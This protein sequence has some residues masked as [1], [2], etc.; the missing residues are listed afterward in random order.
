MAPKSVTICPS[1]DNCPSVYCLGYSSGHFPV[2]TTSRLPPPPSSSANCI[3][4]RSHCGCPVTLLPLVSSLARVNCSWVPY[5]RLI[6]LCC[7]VS[8]VVS[9]SAVFGRLSCCFVLSV[10]SCPVALCSSHPCFLSTH[11]ESPA[12]FFLPFLLPLHQC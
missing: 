6:C 9:C 3:P 8:L 2:S 12:I 10:L 7:P 11:R 1:V 4:P 5:Y